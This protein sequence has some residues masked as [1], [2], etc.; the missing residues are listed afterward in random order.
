MEPWRQGVRHGTADDAVE[1][2][3]PGV[4]RQAIVVDELIDARFGQR[5]AVAPDGAEDERRTEL[6]RQ[7]TAPQPGRARRER[8]Q[9]AA[10]RP[11]QQTQRRQPVAGRARLRHDPVEPRRRGRDARG[12]G[13]DRRTVRGRPCPGDHALVRRN[14]REQLR[15]EIALGLEVD[16]IEVA[17]GAT[18]TAMALGRPRVTPA[19]LRDTAQGVQPHPAEPAAQ[20]VGIDVAGVVGTQLRGARSGRADDESRR[21]PPTAR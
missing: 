2:A 3:R 21:P 20:A 13:L 6:R 19:A 12:A 15:R 1:I 9:V 5:S 7:Q 17:C 8:D 16:Q 4:E 18:E 10:R 11:A 14:A